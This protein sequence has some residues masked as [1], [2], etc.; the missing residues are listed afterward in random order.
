MLEAGY[1]A[2]FV[3]VDAPV[4]GRRLNERNGVK[5]ELPSDMSLPNLSAPG[6]VS[7]TGPVRSYRHSG[8]DASNS[9]QS[10]IPWVK[11]NT[12][13]KIWLKGGKLY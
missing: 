10:V 8:R 11:A 12:S 3:T 13:L 1:D 7:S 4:L 9:W 6:A 2:L 5:F